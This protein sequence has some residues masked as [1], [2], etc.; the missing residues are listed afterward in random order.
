MKVHVID[1]YKPIGQQTTTYEGPPEVVRQQL[2][3]YYTFL[4]DKMGTFRGDTLED[5]LTQLS[6]QSHY[7][8]GVEDDS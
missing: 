2:R 1:M 8:V 6:S 7:I 3:E 4:G 5:Y